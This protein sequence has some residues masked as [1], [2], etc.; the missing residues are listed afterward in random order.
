MSGTL[1]LCLYSPF[2]PPQRRAG[3]P[4]GGR[5][6]KLRRIFGEILSLARGDF[7]QQI[8]SRDQPSLLNICYN[9][10]IVP[11]HKT[12]LKELDVQEHWEAVETV[13]TT[14]FKRLNNTKIN[15]VTKMST[16]FIKIEKHMHI[17]TTLTL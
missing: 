9:Y 12:I 2:P 1:P 10:Y 15:K 5:V 7:E 13:A 17:S 4:F 3:V 8:R 16:P 11:Y 14:L 6:P